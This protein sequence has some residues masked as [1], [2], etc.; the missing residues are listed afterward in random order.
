MHF[1]HRI[2]F[3]LASFRMKVRDFLVFLCNSAVIDVEKKI[4]LS[5]N[6][7]F[8]SFKHKKFILN[9]NRMRKKLC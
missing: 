4:L 8:K 9:I 3:D 5:L 6:A 2:N 7:Y 1:V